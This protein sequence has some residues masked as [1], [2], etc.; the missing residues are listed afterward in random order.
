MNAITTTTESPLTPLPPRVV[1]GLTRMLNGL[2]RSGLSATIP[3]ALAPAPEQRAYLGRRAAALDS[4]LSPAG[5]DRAR[6]EVAFVL[7]FMA[8]RQGD[9]TDRRAK[10]E[11]YASDLAGVPSAALSQACRDYRTGVVGDGKWAPTSGELR[12]RA[13]ALADA[14]YAERGKIQQVLSAKVVDAAPVDQSRKAAVLAHV[15][16]TKRALKA[17]RAINEIARGAIDPEKPAAPQW[18]A[19]SPQEA[20]AWLK[21]HAE[22]PIKP[23]TLSPSLRASL[24]LGGA[25][26]EVAA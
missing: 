14:F 20:T 23:V 2:E 1:D 12:K 16:E 10:L 22:L 6:R 25:S 15:E 13:M 19:Q 7:D 11:V 4:W 21:A 5:P 3:A 18:P 8:A 26:Q 17:A 24:G 9:E